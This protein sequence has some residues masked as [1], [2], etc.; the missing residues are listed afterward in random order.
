MSEPQQ[1]INVGQVAND[2]TGESLRD[3]FNAVNNNFANV[4][5]AGP[6]DSQVVITN[7]RISTNETNLDLILAGNGVG[8]VT[9][10]ST[11]V[12]SIDAVYDLGR[13]NRRFDE[14]HA[15]YYYGNGAYLTGITGNGGGGPN[16]Y[17]S[18]GAPDDAS[19]GDIW[20]ESDTGVQY[21]YF[22]DDTSN[23]WAEME[24]Y[25]S[26]SSGGNGTAN[27]G[28][29]AFAGNNFYNLNGGNIFNGDLTHGYTAGITIPTNGDA[30]AI[31]LNNT[32]GNIIL[33]AGAN[34]D[35]T[36]TWIFGNNGVIT[37]DG[38]LKLAPDSTNAGSY[39][40]IFLTSGP[41]LHLVASAGANLIL[42]KDNSANV[43]TSWNGNAYVQSWNL[44]TGNVGGIWTFS[45]DGSTIFPTLTVQRGDNPSGTITGQTLSF[46][47]PSQE[48]I[49]STADG[50]AS[51]EYSQRLVINPG[52][53]YD[54][55]EGGDIY[56]WAGRGGNG[57]G[58]GGDI[59]I[60]GGQGGASTTGG[61]GGNGGYIR[62]EAGDSATTGGAPGYI[63]ING[64]V[65][66]T[67]A[68]G[69]V[70]IRGGQ[71]Q[72]I[73]G[74]ANITGGYGFDDRGGNVNIWG[75]GSG[76]GQANEGH[77]NIQ[78]GGNTWTFN[79]LGNLTIPGNILGSGNI[80]IAPNSAS[81][82]SYLDIYLTGGPDIHIAS[83]DNSI[84]IG[85]D[86]G[87]NV[88][89]G[90][91]GE[92][93]IRTDNG[94]TPQVWNF[95]NTG[96]LSLPGNTFA[97]N[98]A[99]GDPV[100]ISGST[101]NTGNVTF[102][103]QIVIGTGISNLVSGLYLSPSSSSANALQYLRVRGDVSYEPTHIHFD[104]GNNQYFNQFIGDD[105]KYVLLSNLATL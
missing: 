80:L 82:S 19:I 48:A 29:W 104:T 15:V 21:L 103:D 61:V 81:A 45:G 100:I 47:D 17:F 76:N 46:G 74:D 38:N 28:N 13:A 2:G 32:Y 41:D 87:A 35:P 9:V 71:G 95:D 40:D 50:T 77:V 73:G 93:S 39:L 14:V 36:A 57:S 102:S 83:N 68:G 4:W 34:S 10:A 11:T 25:Q 6:V 51:N 63:D 27:T 64:G 70:D 54:Y 62:I 78:T 72:T 22:N 23:Q 92:V 30:N 53:G 86:T 97:V 5:A 66:Y 69:Y 67:G 96:N 52:Q 12:P 58:S 1:Q 59:K 49:I 90:N 98:Y 101:A 26:F 91:D 16:V 43:M 60:R 99:N 75:G 3:A 8:N 65:N 105:N 56:L 88:F 7:N 55:G 84:V 24:A 33:Q 18:Q 79:P 20:I 42:G 44:D 31:L 94:A 85:R 89:V 37:A